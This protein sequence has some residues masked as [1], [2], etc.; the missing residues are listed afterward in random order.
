MVEILA[1][2]TLVVVGLMVGVELSVAA[3]MNPIFDRLP[4]AG[5]LGARSDGASVLGR[6]MPRWYIASLVL[7]AG[8]MA[9]VWGQPQV[10]AV[11]G[12]AALLALSIVMS[13]VLLVPINARVARWS[14]E[15]A[16]ADGQQQ[17]GQWDRFHLARI[18][19]ILTAFVLLTF[20]ATR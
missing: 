14:A 2:V 3:F 17:L 4:N 11:V 13:V 20:A 19:V 18:G 6:V 9:L 5:G 10:W 1:G 15:G 12:A 7:A 16:P 8:W